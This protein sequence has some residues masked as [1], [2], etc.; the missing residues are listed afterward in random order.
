M[1]P[2]RKIVRSFNEEIRSFAE[3]LPWFGLATDKLVLNLDGSLL[4]AFEYTGVDVESSSDIQLEVALNAMQGALQAFD[5]HNTIWTFLDKRRKK[6]LGSSKASNEV[7][8]FVDQSWRDA[9][10]DGSLGSVRHVMFFAY[11]PFGGGGGFFDEVAAK[12]AADKEPFVKTLFAVAV[13]RLRRKQQIE[14]MEGKLESAVDSFEKQLAS[15]IGTLGAHVHIRRLK[16]D[17]LL[18]ELSNRANLASPRSTVTVPPNGHYFLN[19]LLP[20]DGVFREQSGMFR[21]EGSAGSRIVSMHAVKGYPGRATNDPIE[22]LM[23]VP[24]DFSLVQMFRF[25]DSEKA[26]S[27]ISDQENHYRSNVKSPIIQ[28]VEKFSGVESERINLGMAALADDAQAALIEATADNVGFGYHSMALQVITEDGKTNERSSQLLQS[29]MTNAGYGLVRENVNAVSALTLTFPGAADAVLRQT[30][31]STSNLA[32]LTILR[33]LSSGGR[34]NRHLSEQRGTPTESLALLPTRTDVPEFFNFHVGDVGHFFI[35]GPA[36][37]GK[38]TFI[39]FLITLWQRNEPCRTIVLDK[40]LS[41]YI[42]VK[43]L[44]GQHIDLRQGEPSSA[45]MSPMRWANRPEDYPKL[46]RWLELALLAFNET[47]LSV[48]DVQILDRSI[49]LMAQQVGEKSLSALHAMI[50]GQDKALAERLVVWTKGQRY[51]DLFDNTEDTFALADICAIELGT[52]LSDEHLAPPVLGYLFEVIEES[53]D[54]SRPT[55]IYLEEAWYLLSNPTFRARF[56]DYIKT[57]RKRNA[58]VGI[59]TQSL[60]DIRKSP[61]SSTLND[62]IKTRIFLPNMQAFD[63]IDV[64]RDMLGLRADEVEVIRSARQKREYFI[65]QDDRRRL[66]DV[67]LPPDIL[68]LTRS[69]PK[70]KVIFERHLQSGREDWL[71]N[72]MQEVINA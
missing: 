28:A 53:V 35:V 40:G 27:F 51:G 8:R 55:F 32:D 65:V 72:Y 5:D 49:S 46:Q 30:F 12:S 14:R 3:L 43:A 60:A 39:N 62:N 11:Q 57:M 44:G 23:R 7:T 48:R 9:V 66:V 21:F 41:N 58:F 50:K 70:A 15:F 36:G 71:S 69:D 25:V 13:Q 56:E 19:T 4:A 54:S 16:E 47:P 45:K 2:L 63:S 59:A 20:T 64:Y 29:V 34:W 67:F 22:A 10:D 26:K 24:V 18:A 38:T 6:F 52:L 42:T 1:T 61:I 33:T 17:K 37:A 31:A 68:S